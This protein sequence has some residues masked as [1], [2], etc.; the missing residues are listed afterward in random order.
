MQP[1]AICLRLFLQVVVAA[2]SRTFCTAGSSRPIRTAMMAITTSS[3]MRVKARRRMAHSSR[4]DRPRERT[5]AHPDG[6]EKETTKD[7]KER[8]YRGGCRPFGRSALPSRTPR[9]ANHPKCS[10]RRSN[11]VAREQTDPGSSPTKWQR[12]D[13]RTS[14]GT[15]S[16]YTPC[17]GKGKEKMRIDGWMLRRC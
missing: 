3:S 2:A 10:G 17:W 12:E 11:P 6:H 4:M 13:L 16:C 5:D 7:E 15:S 14:G 1:S 8:D 9:A